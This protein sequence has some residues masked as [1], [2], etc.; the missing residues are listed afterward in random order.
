MVFHQQHFIAFH[1]G[2]QFTVSGVN[3]L[4]PFLVSC[5]DTTQLSSTSLR[6]AQKAF[7]ELERIMSQDVD[8][9]QLRF[10]LLPSS[11]RTGPGTWVQILP[12]YVATVQSDVGP[13]DAVRI[14]AVPMC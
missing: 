3:M 12:P 2:V 10:T 5:R 11:D 14:I 8:M 7:L 13:I 4:P 9:S 1:C 6:G